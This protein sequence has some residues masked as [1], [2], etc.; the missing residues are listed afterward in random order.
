MQGQLETLQQTLKEAEQRFETKCENMSFEFT[1]KNQE[2]DEALA[3]KNSEITKALDKLAVLQTELDNTKHNYDEKINNKDTEIAHLEDKINK[4]IQD[5]NL[6][7]SSIEDL[8][9]E[10]NKIK[11][12]ITEEKKEKNRLIQALSEKEADISNLGN[13]IKELEE[14]NKKQSE[15]LSDTEKLRSQEIS[16]LKFKL[17]LISE[18]KEK[19]IKRLQL[20]LQEKIEFGDKKMSEGQSLLD[21]IS[22]LETSIKDKNK[23]IEAMKSQLDTTT[24]TL[25]QQKIDFESQLKENEYNISL[26]KEKLQTVT[27]FKDETITDL[28]AL[29]AEKDERVIALNIKVNKLSGDVANLEEELKESQAELEIGRNEFI[30]LR[31]EHEAVIARN[32]TNTALKNQEMRSLHDKINELQQKNVKLEADKEKSAIDFA[33]EKE[34]SF[35]CMLCRPFTTKYFIEYIS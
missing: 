18:E 15:I 11:M 17:D 6:N 22:E 14:N 30:V 2:L 3:L 21:T 8:K 16:E 20:L 28:K 29:L 5:K 9:E 24:N 1:S 25:E 10:N 4:L 33:L 31:E 13:L 35:N 23:E 26:L 32:E 7:D 34:V 12:E 19:E 27:H